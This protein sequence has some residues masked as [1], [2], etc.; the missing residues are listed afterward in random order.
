MYDIFIQ[1]LADYTSHSLTVKFRNKNTMNP[2]GIVIYW[3]PQ[4]IAK[5]F[6]LKSPEL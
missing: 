2:V 1:Y 6:V 5:K 3:N 4:K